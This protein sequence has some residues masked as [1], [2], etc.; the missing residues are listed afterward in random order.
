MPPILF[1]QILSKYPVSVDLFVL[2]LRVIVDVNTDG[3]ETTAQVFD[4]FVDELQM[5]GMRAWLISICFVHHH[6][7][8]SLVV[9]GHRLMSEIYRFKRTIERGASR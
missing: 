6:K 8:F 3:S 2:E 5:I 9:M 4:F 1:L 7:V